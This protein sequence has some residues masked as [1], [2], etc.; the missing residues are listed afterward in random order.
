MK[1][2]NHLDRRLREQLLAGRRKEGDRLMLADDILRA[3]LDGSRPLTANERMALEASPLTVRRLRQLAIDRRAPRKS[4]NDDAWDGSTGMLRAAD[5]GTLARLTTDDGYWI[6]HFSDDDGGWQL[7]LQ[8]KA[9][10]PFT[11]RLLRERPALCVLD[12]EGKVLLQGRLDGDGECEGPWQAPGDPARYFQQH[13]ARFT[14]RP[15]G[16]G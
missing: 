7:T 11:A 6:L 3:A 12:A 9:C 4:A 5:S 15:V 2:T 14:V 10:A 16:G 1:R 13:G 8:L